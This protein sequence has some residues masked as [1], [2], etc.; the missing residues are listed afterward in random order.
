MK[1][2]EQL[3]KNYLHSASEEDEKERRYDLVPDHIVQVVLFEKPQLLAG[4]CLRGP[5]AALP[6]GH[7][8]QKSHLG[9]FH[10]RSI[11]PRE[12]YLRFANRT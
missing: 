7:R 6:L 5:P 10:I 2:I 11:A 8:S 1:C 9:E 12:S 3:Q 4:A